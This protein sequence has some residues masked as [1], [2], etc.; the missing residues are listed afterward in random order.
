MI[1]KEISHYRIVELIGG[2]GMGDVYRA[3]D[4]SLDRTVA[5]KAIKPSERGSPEAERQFLNEAR[6]VSRIDHP[7]VVMLIEVLEQ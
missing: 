4:L 7:N 1:G 5:I 3:E 6:T 2:G